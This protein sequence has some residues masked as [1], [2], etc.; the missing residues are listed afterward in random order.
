MF[1]KKRIEELERRLDML[2][3]KLENSEAIGTVMHHSIGWTENNNRYL[4]EKA[5]TNR[6]M[7]Y[8]LIA[9]LGVMYTTKEARLVKIKKKNK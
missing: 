2:Y 1:Y 6:D 3:R 4:G 5:N 9:Y 7:V 8:D